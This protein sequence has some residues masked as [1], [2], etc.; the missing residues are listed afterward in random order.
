MIKQHISEYK[1]E[2]NDFFFYL[3]N[4]LRNTGWKAI[5]KV[6]HRHIRRPW[7]RNKIN[8]FIQ[9]GYG[10]E[11]GCG[12]WTIAPSQKT[13]LSDRFST[14]A[15]NQSLAKVF[16][17]ASEIPYEN[18]TFSFILSEHVLEH[19][20]DPIKTIKE[21]K[22]VLKRTGKIFL[23]LPHAGRTFDRDRKRTSYNDLVLR[24]SEKQDPIKKEILKDWMDN[25]MNKGLATHYRHIK[26]ED[27][28]H[29]GTIHYNVWIPK[30]I[31]HLLKK[32]G[33]TINS[34]FSVVPDRKD[35]F[36]VIAEKSH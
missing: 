20:Y 18:D 35:S 31:E 25:V 9:S 11:I 23:F 6:F 22:R 36:L 1:F 28:L 10:L 14:H 5:Y 33:F 34:S 7:S 12:N 15:G 26:P 21:W 17:D 16:F 27:M 29:D 32:V 13:I 3:K 4:V 19:I 24:G 2:K 8:N 30:D